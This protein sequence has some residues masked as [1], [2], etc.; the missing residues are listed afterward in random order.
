MCRA[1]LRLLSS[2]CSVMD[3]PNQMMLEDTRDSKWSTIDPS[4]W[5]DLQLTSH[6]LLDIYTTVFQLRPFEVFIMPNIW[7]RQI[8]VGELRGG[9]WTIKRIRCQCRI[10]IPF[11]QQKNIMTAQKGGHDPM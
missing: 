3:S 11:T 10:H 4:A 6:R 1:A 2:V 5:N 7:A 8:G 9:K